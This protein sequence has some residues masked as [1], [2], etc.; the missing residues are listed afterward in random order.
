[1]N[2]ARQVP[3]VRE[4]FAEGVKRATAERGRLVLQRDE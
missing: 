2:Q 3:Q 1:M 4:A